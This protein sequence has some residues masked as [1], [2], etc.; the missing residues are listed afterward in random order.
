MR[1]RLRSSG[2][3]AA[4][5]GDYDRHRDDPR[6][7]TNV[8]RLGRGRRTERAARQGGHWRS[9][10]R[11]L[12][13]AFFRAGRLQPLAPESAANP[14]AGGSRVARLMTV[15][16]LERPRTE[17]RRWTPKSLQLVPP[18]LMS[19]SRDRPSHREPKAE[20]AA[21][22]VASSSRFW[23]WSRCYFSQASWPWGFC[24]AS[25]GKRRLWTPPRRLK[26]ASQPWM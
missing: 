13:H 11:H 15:R 1:L 8:S 17:R 16:K 25:S 21:R 18:D 2:I 9:A 22:R 7:V 5:S 19:R 24:L 14:I 26:T 10:G 12:L 4:S 3:H 6:H 20:S 23:R